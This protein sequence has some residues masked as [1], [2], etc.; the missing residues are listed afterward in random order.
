M[1]DV[2]ITLNAQLPRA[3]AAFNNKA[4]ATSNLNINLTK[5]LI[6]AT[7]G[8][9]LFMAL[10]LGCCRKQIRNTWKVFK[11]GA[12]DGWKRSVAPIV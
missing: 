8:A 3:K 6:T 4:L 10:Q 2:H 9:Q 11:C 12:G 7:F 5:K 1:Q